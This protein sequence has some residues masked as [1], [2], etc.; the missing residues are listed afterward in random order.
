MQPVIAAQKL[1]QV[2]AGEV[3]LR[4]RAVLAVV[5]DLAR[6]D[7]VTGLQVIGAE[8]VRRRF[9]RRGEDDGRAVH[10]VAAQHA[11]GA[12]AERIVRHDA[13]KAAV[14]AEVGQRQRNVGLAA[15]VTCLKGGRDTDL[16]VVRRRQAKHDLAEG[17]EARR[18]LSVTI[19][20]FHG[21]PSFNRKWFPH[22]EKRKTVAP[23]RGD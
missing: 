13:E 17:D 2:D 21:I 22:H 7:P 20:F 18:R 23:P 3:V 14:H 11:H 1:A 10:V 12:L 5:G 19:R 6:A 9:L 15:A 8:A 16:F 4:D